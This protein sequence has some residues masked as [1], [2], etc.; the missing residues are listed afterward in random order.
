[1]LLCSGAC[2]SPTLPG[3]GKVGYNA[4]LQGGLVSNRSR[5]SLRP[6]QIARTVLRNSFGAVIT[7]G[8]VST[9]GNQSWVSWEFKGGAAYRWNHLGLV[10]FF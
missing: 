8:N 7:L 9:E 6:G 10:L 2:V 5:Y 4:T 1:M 3:T